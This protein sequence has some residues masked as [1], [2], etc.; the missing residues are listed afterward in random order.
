MSLSTAALINDEGRAPADKAGVTV[1]E[2]ADKYQLQGSV[3][4]CVYI[5]VRVCVNTELSG[6]VVA[7]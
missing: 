5:C 7:K 2:M 1:G 6:R 4:V 3:C